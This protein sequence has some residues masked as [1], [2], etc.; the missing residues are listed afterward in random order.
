[1]TPSLALTAAPTPAEE[2]GVRDALR[3]ANTAAGFPH[4]VRPLVVVIRDEAGAVIGGL[5]GRTNWSWLYVENLAVPA[6][7]RGQGIG[8]RALAMA[9]AEA[10]ARGC[11][12]IRLDTY[13]FQARGFYEKQGYAVVGLIED[14]P[15]GET[16]FTMTKRLD[17]AQGES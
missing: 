15:P 3:E 4:D 6:A 11:V 7:L 16:R 1:V 17:R 14:C 10:R 12:G 9:E 8:R 2:A 5:W 13:S